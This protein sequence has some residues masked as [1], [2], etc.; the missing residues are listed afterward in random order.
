MKLP[1][2]ALRAWVDVPWEARELA[3]R[4]TLSGFEVEAVDAAAPAFE[5][6]VVA[7]ILSAEPHPRA[8]KLR[9]CRVVLTQDEAGAAPLQIVCGASNARAGLVSALAR[10]GA[11]LP[12]GV[13]I[14]A[15][16][17]RGVESQGML[18]SARELGLG[19]A[20]DGILELPEGL[21]LGVDLRAAL[22]LDDPILEVNVTANRGDALSV[23][24]LAREVAALCDRALKHPALGVDVA[25]A[26]TRAAA[27]GEARLA[28][29][30]PAQGG[31]GRLLARVIRG[32]DNSTLSPVWLRERLRRSGLRSI[33]PV[34]DVTNYVMLELGQPMHAYDRAILQGPMV[35]RWARAQE[36]LQL[37]DGRD[38]EL[39]ADVLVIADAQSILGLAGIMGGER[40][41]ITSATRDIA[42]EVAW[43]A[44]R[45]IAGRARRYGLM[46]D[47]SQ[48]FER[49]VDYRI[50]E[51]ALELATHL[52]LQIAGGQAGPVTIA[53]Q[54]ESLPRS[55]P[56]PLRLRQLERLLGAS[57]TAEQIERPLRS[58]GM[59]VRAAGEP[60][61]RT[62]SVE[63]PSWR[64]D[65]G[66]EADL[67]EEVARINGLDAIAERNAVLPLAPQSLLSSQI[68]ERVVLRTLAARG[69][70]EAISFAFIDPALQRELFGNE[71]VLELAN[72]IA[73]DMAVMRTSLWPGL[74]RA[75]GENLRRQQQ[76]VRLFEI[77]NRF[78]VDA[79]GRYR[80]EKVLAALVLGARLPEQWGAAATAVDFFDL[81]GDLEALL[82][83]G[84]A[85]AEFQFEPAALGCL[86]PGRSARIV[87]GGAAIGYL[88]ELHP[89]LLPAMDLT[90]APILFE[91]DYS[92]TFVAKA[93]QFRETS[94]YPLIRRDIS[95]TIPETV[96]FRRISERVSVAAASLLQELRIFDVY[97]GK[98]VEIGRKSVALGLI[99]Q[100]LS[101][102]LT[103]EEADRVVE[104]V[105]ADLRSNLDARIRE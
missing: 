102:T 87:R 4:L 34:V 72:P 83:L 60:G 93:A 42:L 95:F 20:S 85:A 104:A 25:L 62:W 78:R 105:R 51:R 53:E 17:L 38:I 44:P 1:L 55:A 67:I 7:K 52:M 27:A 103:D 75:A 79:E 94:R 41:A 6:V 48:R 97:Q 23:L 92:A 47:A 37:L 64:F 56:V 19:E 89:R 32:V 100:D 8:E 45:A 70:Q 88:G 5:G 14:Q 82:A 73:A 15:A 11:V 77:A 33:S 69:F 81:K 57:V 80:E 59:T 68:D 90:Y 26:A 54:P 49:G 46:T 96:A 12:G 101:R 63:P 76:R 30:L 39:A 40:S 58:L 21:P 66:I 13:C 18:C 29:E 43:F 98:E 61:A 28:L 16:Q 84:G 9:V 86:H 74:L 71:P 65:I 3:R 99:L 2:S 91:V 22:D 24:G 31:A 10:V 50:Q 36:R 35:A